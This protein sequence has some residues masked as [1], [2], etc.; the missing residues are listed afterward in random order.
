MHIALLPGDGIG[1]EVTRAS[2]RVLSFLVPHAKLTSHPI[3]FGAY[4]EFGTSLP[5]ETLE[6]VR[7]ADATL[8]GAVTTPVGV[9]DYR[10]PV[11][12]LRQ[13][14]KLFAN[15][16]PVR[17]TPLASSRGDVDL[18]IVRE[19]S[20]GL[21]SGRERR[22]VDGDTAVAERVVTRSACARIAR[23]AFELARRR[24]GQVTIVHKAN[25]LRETCGLFLEAAMD[26]AAEYSDV[27][28]SDM[29]V[30]ACAMR[31]IRSPESFNVIVTSNLFGD[32]LSDEA[33][34]L[35]GGLGLARSA[36][37][38]AEASVFEPVHGS[39]PD[40][41][42]QGIANPMA[43][44]GAVAMLL[45]HLGESEASKALDRAIEEAV[46]EGDT[47]PDLGGEL[48]TDEVIERLL[49]RL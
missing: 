38:G 35:V 44:L 48:R 34:E 16:R 27:P 31:L 13:R 10:S 46:R 18:V 12:Q 3:G 4:R 14:L 29:L 22:S 23:F 1:P 8:L 17:T 41:A 36:N 19:N 28:T 45:D 40:I 5:E 42:G 11:L 26:V 32:I 15:V 39:A 6:A 33:A 20:E 30:D 2:S 43:A 49:A 21:Y 37:V 7:D 47:P 24:Q 25:V 9:P